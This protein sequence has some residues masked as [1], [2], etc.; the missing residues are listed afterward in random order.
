MKAADAAYVKLV[1]TA[2]SCE[3]QMQGLI[4][5]AV[6][7][8]PT[9]QAGIDI[10]AQFEDLR[11]L[12]LGLSTQLTV[13]FNRF[14]S[15]EL[16][17]T[18]RLYQ[19]AKDRPPS[20]WHMPPAAGAIAW[21]RQLHHVLEGPIGY[22]WRKRDICM[23]NGEISRL[24]HYNVLSK[25]LVEYQLLWHSH[26]VSGLRDLNQ[27][28][29]VPLLAVDDH[30]ATCVNIDPRLDTLVQEVVWMEKLG[31]Q[32]PPEA[33]FFAAKVQK[34]KLIEGRLGN[35]LER[36]KS[37]RSIAEH[38][39]ILGKVIILLSSTIDG[40]LE[41]G[42]RVLTWFVRGPRTFPHIADQSPNL[43]LL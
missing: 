40:A 22:F 29:Q 33:Q 31:F 39:L 13:L 26:W 37:L 1:E 5:V 34:I 28:V 18:R 41:P 23:A 15:N 6:S 7:S 9:T 4:A 27:A 25:S 35:L 11:K 21:A 20:P 14:C 36:R 42:F 43:G 12:D 32:V 19:K 2:R 38:Q 16:E 10:I 30:G 24:R 8:T 3:A 17:A